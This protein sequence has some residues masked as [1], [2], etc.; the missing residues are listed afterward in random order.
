M[1]TAG[2]RARQLYPPGTAKYLFDN[3]LYL[4]SHCPMSYGEGQRDSRKLVTLTWI[5]AIIETSTGA[6][7]SLS[8]ELGSTEL[9]GQE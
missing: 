7:G 2:A 1:P 8:C 6:G 5:T 9:V 4:L 3:D